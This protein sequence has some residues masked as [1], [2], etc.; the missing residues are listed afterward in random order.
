MPKTL[1]HNANIS[2]RRMTVLLLLMQ[3]DQIEQVS[4]RGHPLFRITHWLLYQHIALLRL[5][6]KSRRKFISQV[7]PCC[8]QAS[9]RARQRGNLPVAWPSPYASVLEVAR[10]RS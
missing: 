3:V 10:L 9:C 4:K 7:S 5:R 8:A 2:I 6:L 1:E